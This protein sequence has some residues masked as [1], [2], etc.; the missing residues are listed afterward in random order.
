MFGGNFAPVGWAKC[1]GQ[2]LNI[3]SN[4]ALFSILGTTYG[5]N[6]S[7]TFGLPDLRGRVPMHAGAGPSLTNRTLGEKS[8]QETV[9]L[10]TAQLPAHS[11]GLRCNKAAGNSDTPVNSFPAP[12]EAGTEMFHS[13]SD[14][15]MNAGA[16]QNTGS[17]QAHTNLP[18][19]QA[20]NFIIALQGIFP[21]QS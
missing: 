8:G 1:D 9:T 20:V 21:S 4:T 14:Q 3:A 10:T 6:G 18:P 12:D 2:L 17:G 11:H 15:N 16:I 19:F 7:S 5:G 13:A